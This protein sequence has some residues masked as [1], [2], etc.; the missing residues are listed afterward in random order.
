[1]KNIG[2][3]IYDLATEYNYTVVNGIASYFEN[4]TDIRL[5]ITTVKKPH[6]SEG[7]FDYQFWSSI[8]L[9][10]TEEMDGYIIVPNS[11]TNYWD[12]NNLTESLK[13]FTKKPVVSVSV[14]LKL[15]NSKTA[16]VSFENSYNFLISHL[17][18]KHN[19][20]KIAF[21]SAENTYSPEAAQRLEAFKKALKNNNL[22]FNPD[23]IL[24]GDFTSDTASKYILNHYKSKEDIPF[25]AIV[26]ANDY[27][28]IGCMAA[29]EQIGVKC[30]KDIIIAGFDDSPMAS[31]IHP[32]IT[33]INQFIPNNGYQAAKL[34]DDIL[35]DCFVSENDYCT[36]AFPVYRQSCGCVD[37]SIQTNAYIDKDGI[38]H[39]INDR[40]ISEEYNFNLAS[41][42]NINNICQLLNL[43]D[44]YTSLDSLKYSINPM[45]RLTHINSLS[46]CLYK[47]PVELNMDDDFVLPEQAYVTSLISKSQELNIH[48]TDGLN[49]TYFNP[50][51]YLI[52]DDAKKKECGIFYLMPLFMR[53]KNFG[54]MIFKYDFTLTYVVP[55]Y[56]KILTHTILQCYANEQAEK[57]TSRLIQKTEN[58][59]FQSKTDELT[60]LFNRRGFLQFGASL[61]DLSLA[62]E[63]EGL[64]FF[65]DMDG[66]KKIND[67]YGHKIG[68]LAIK[69]Q[70]VI[71]QKAFRES[72]LIG[73]LS[74]DEFG[75][76]APGLKIENLKKFR[77]RLNKISEEESKKAELPIILSISAGYEKF[78]SDHNNL[79]DLLI[80]ADKRLYEEK[81][82]KHGK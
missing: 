77:E 57:V 13:E 32:T 33:T 8:E 49:K 24:P 50:K 66:L 2:V 16:L 62:A 63:K 81:L 12:F 73:R 27:T 42:D 21:F 10:K 78:D 1:M 26:C 43:A 71:L 30:P 34:L 46:V 56:S 67:T 17:L 4:R 39:G 61:I 38:F 51:K 47:N 36:E 15:P 74:G 29:F 72:D 18:N 65:C 23:F 20:T 25:D 31:K 58:L 75:I 45:L 7:F 55:L 69:T 54:Y 79:Q 3:I 59:D 14:P 53:N 44:A 5:V 52:P 64:V 9:L 37:S 35:N 80:A 48:L 76:V 11:F 6:S 22:D 68:D 70:A 82:I 28:A 41:S 60:S 40:P 19:I